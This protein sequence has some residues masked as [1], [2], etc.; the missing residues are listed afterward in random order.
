MISKRIAS[1]VDG[2]SSALDALKYGAGLKIDRKT[3][4]YLDKSHRTRI[5][6][7]G[8]VENSVYVNQD[9][10]VMLEIIDLAALEMQTNCELNTKV[11]QENKIAHFIFSFD[12]DRPSEAVLRDTEDSTEL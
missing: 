8:L 4:E 6:G 3:G 9:T 2:K 7:F 5:G 12:Q 1:R 11:S 10:A